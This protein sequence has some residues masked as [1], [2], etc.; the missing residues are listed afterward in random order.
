M[1]YE[2][3][4]V[5]IF[6]VILL[7]ILLNGRIE[8]LANLSN[9]I[10]GKIIL[11]CLIVFLSLRYGTTCGLLGAFVYLLL[12]NKYKEALSS[13]KVP[14]KP[15]GCSKDRDCGACQYKCNSGNCEAKKLEGSEFIR[16]SFVGSRSSQYDRES[17]EDKLNKQPNLKTISA[18]C[19]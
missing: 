19:H 15:K 3:F 11:V 5:E 1:N 10:S 17:V 14:P 16:E 18:Q 6:L 4:Y 7:L 13:S 2:K 8:M 12:N 9:D